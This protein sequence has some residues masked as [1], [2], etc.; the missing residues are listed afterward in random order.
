MD[1]NSLEFSPIEKNH[2]TI[3][4]STGEIA[5]RFYPSLFWAIATRLKLL[6]PFTVQKNNMVFKP[7]IIFWGDLGDIGDAGDIGDVLV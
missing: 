3:L 2:V 1:K 5:L 4:F 6:L 7:K